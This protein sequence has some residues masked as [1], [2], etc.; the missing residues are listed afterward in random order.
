[1]IADQFT[2]LLRGNS[3]LLSEVLYLVIVSAAGRTFDDVVDVT[4][5]HTDPEASTRVRS[6]LWSRKDRR[7]IQIN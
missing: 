6:S 2:D 7:L 1:M 5:F 4:T 3:V